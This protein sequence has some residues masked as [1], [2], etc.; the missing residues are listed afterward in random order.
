MKLTR[1]LW[2]KISEDLVENAALDAGSSHDHFE[3]GDADRR[4]L[5]GV[6]ER[7]AAGITNVACVSK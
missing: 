5:G 4:D 7:P 6:I 2:G 1:S 3:L